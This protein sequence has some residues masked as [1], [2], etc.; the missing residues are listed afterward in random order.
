MGELE[1]IIH[2]QVGRF[3]SLCRLTPAY[4]LGEIC[5]QS[6]EFG[7]IAEPLAVKEIEAP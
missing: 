5:V 1:S 7:E 2:H 6:A 3:R 4:G